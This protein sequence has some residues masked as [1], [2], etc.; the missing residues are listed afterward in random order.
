MSV[1]YIPGWGDTMRRDLPELG[2]SISQIVSP[3]QPILE[4]IAANPQLMDAYKLLYQANPNLAEQLGGSKLTDSL[5]QGSVTKPVEQAIAIQGEKVKQAPLETTIL[6]N[7]AK[8]SDYEPQKALLGIQLGQANLAHDQSVNTLLENQVNDTIA[9][10]GLAPFS[11]Q[12]LMNNEYSPE[13]LAQ[14]EAAAG[15]GIANQ[16]RVYIADKAAAA[17][18][19]NAGMRANVSGELRDDFMRS[20]GAANTRANE[21]VKQMGSSGVSSDAKKALANE[22]NTLEM[23]RWAYAQML[24]FS[25][26]PV[27]FKED[28]KFFG[29]FNSWKQEIVDPTKEGWQAGTITGHPDLNPPAQPTNKQ[30]SISISG[31]NYNVDQ[32]DAVTAQQLAQIPS[33]RLGDALAEMQVKNPDVFKRLPKELQ[34]LATAPKKE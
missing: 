12:R 15:P 5:S 29:M 24:G 13:V 20:L 32:Q 18:I 6:G 2:K 10:K 11:I 14:Y 27:Q 9:G 25:H 8:A 7:A 33:A 4:A 3:A 16:I 23:Q 17:S 30:I 26:T 19:Y 21:I 28:P 34:A 31:K 22:F 1:P